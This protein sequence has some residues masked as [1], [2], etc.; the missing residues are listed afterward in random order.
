MCLQIKTDM[1]CFSVECREL[2]IVCMSLR[3]KR[4]KTMQKTRKSEPPTR[5]K[6]VCGVVSINRDRLLDHI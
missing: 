6:R 5:D 2:H 1:R 3:K 4:K